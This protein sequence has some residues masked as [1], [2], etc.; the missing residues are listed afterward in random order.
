MNDI[1]DKIDLTM[2]TL[3]EETAYQKFF[4]KKLKEFNVTSPAKLSADKKK[5]FFNQIEKE[6][7]KDK[8]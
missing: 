5:E 1:I 8:D 7:T 4:K 6:W 2:G 3:T